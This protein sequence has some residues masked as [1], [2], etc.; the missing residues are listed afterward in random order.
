MNN[1]K[2]WSRFKN[3]LCIRPD[4]IGDVLMTT[5]AI[6]AFRNAVAR[7][8]ITLLASGSGAAIARHVP[9]VDDCIRFD[10][11]WYKHTIDT[12]AAPDLAE[13]AEQLR[14][15]KFDAA[16]IFTVFSQSPLPTAMLCHMAGI[17]R[18][19][20][21]CRE[22]PY[23]LV[24]DWIPDEEPFY[25][26]RHEVKRQLELVRMLGARSEGRQP[27]SLAVPKGGSRRALHLLKSM[28]ID[29]GGDWLLMHPGAS[30]EKRRYPADE[31]RAA[32]R[33]V[34][35]ATGFKVLLTGTA[36]ERSLVERIA[37]GGNGKI[38]SLA[39]RLDLDALIGL[40]DRAPLIV[41]NNTGPVHIAAAVNT[42]VVVLYALTNPQHAPWGVPHCVLP[43]DV[44]RQMRSRNVLVR[45]AGERA[46]PQPAG[47]ASHEQVV[48]A[49]LQLL[50]ARSS[51]ERRETG[52]V[53]TGRKNDVQPPLEVT[54]GFAS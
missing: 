42:P 30:E 40:I 13:V 26:L 15:R 43:F 25:E 50:H 7:R 54:S 35:E 22:N 8:R 27:L 20:A 18:V 44:A 19:A 51:V 14:A 2:D 49:T 34:A 39:G 45:Y 31:F 10:P 53:C 38:V 5:P 11:P 41:S 6:R 23:H 37:S 4:N 9:E 48:Q 33:R 12:N 32:A 17:P 1:R 21:Y 36:N 29:P 52:L 24:T 28:G 3:V 16:V 47:M 46:F